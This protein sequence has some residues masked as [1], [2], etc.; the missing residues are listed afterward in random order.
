MWYGSSGSRVAYSS[1]RY[2]SGASLYKVMSSGLV[3]RLSEVASLVLVLVLVLV[4]GGA[5][6]VVDM[7]IIMLQCDL[8]LGRENVNDEDSSGKWFEMENADA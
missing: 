1:S 6:V 4:S 3:E 8:N 7:Y 5:S 2:S